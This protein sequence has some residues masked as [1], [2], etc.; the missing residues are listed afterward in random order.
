ML[1]GLRQVCVLSAVSLRT[2]PQ[3][4]GPSLVIVIGVAGVVAV[5]LSVLSI[6]S[7]LVRTIAGSGR[8]DRAIV[9]QRNA[10]SENTS[11]MERSAADRIQFAP[12]IRR[13]DDGQ[14]IVSTEAL[15][16]LRV[17][18]ASGRRGNVMVRGVSQ[19][20]FALRPEMK[21]V[22]GRAMRPG[23]YEL[24][25]G[26]KA[27]AQFKGLKLNDRVAFRGAEWTIVGVF[28]SA[29]DAHEMELLADVDMVLSAMQRNVVNSIS[30][31]LESEGAYEAFR[32]SLTTEPSLVV[33]I[34]RESEYYRLQSE[35]LQR[36][37]SF[38]AYVVSGIMALGAMFGAANTMYSAVSARRMEIATLR[39]VGF[40]PNAVLV[41]VILEAMLLAVAG[42][43]LGA[44]IVWMLLSG[45]TFS[46]RMGS[47]RV[48]AQLSL[49]ADLVALGVAWAC[50]I[51]ILGALAP[52]VRAARQPIA[53]ALRET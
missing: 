24:V 47:G 37:W 46:T 34:S 1:E 20:V 18:D 49:G 14:P 36:S 25:V 31:L 23:F 3:R 21:L 45:H 42:A 5:L 48:M 2:I 9:M 8:A 32:D 50:M 53:D 26:R 22:A 12:G 6:S 11:M 17:V 39:A 4:P 27:L 29:G 40:G 16:P 15:T 38:V 41:S 51:S 43:L 19:T 44:A 52:A 28:S 30:V 7:S 13:T 33:K 10:V 35:P